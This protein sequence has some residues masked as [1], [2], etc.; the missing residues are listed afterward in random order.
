MSKAFTMKHI[1]I[2]LLCSGSLFAQ[3][4]EETAIIA[5]IQQLFE[6]MLKKDSTLLRASLHP[7]ARLATTYTDKKG[8]PQFKSEDINGFV[9]SI[10]TATHHLE[11]KI[12][13]YKVQVDGNLATV[14]TDYTFYV[15]EKLSHCGV[16][17]FELFQTREGW[18]I[19]SIVDTRRRDN[20]IEE[21]ETPLNTFMDAWHKA[22][23]EADEDTFFGSMTEDA[24]YLGT[25][26]S[27]RWLRDELK[28]WSKDYFER[29]SAWSFTAT[30]RNWMFS[31]DG[32]MAWF[33]ELL[34][35]WMG[36]CRGSGVVVQTAEGWKLKHY[37]LAVTVYNDAIEEFKKINKKVEKK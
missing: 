1:L 6:G 29:E 4:S 21:H 3:S 32:K 33:D 31:E 17:S 18:K 10:G 14:W 20:C 28:E 30:E 13:S 37:N 8:N 35:T 34:D 25:D 27:E 11:E 2:L 23:A 7:N 12:W 24:I 22:A 36:I 16:N 5:P 15:D 26:P 19:T 9:K